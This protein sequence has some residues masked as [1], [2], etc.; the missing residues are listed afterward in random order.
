MF[1]TNLKTTPFH[2]LHVRLG[3]KMVPFA[4]YAMPVQ[5]PAGVKEE[6]LHTRAK[7]GL[8]D[9]A[10]MGQL[11]LDGEAASAAL[12]KLVVGNIQGLACKSMRYTLF[13][14]GEGGILD[15][16]IVTKW[17][18]HLHLVVNAARKD[19][20][21]QHMRDNLDCPIRTLEDRALLALQG[22]SAELALATLEPGVMELGFMK[23]DTFKIVGAE[24]QVSR[25]GYTGE[26]GFE[27]SIPTE[28]AVEIA[29]LL[30]EH[31]DV[32]PIGLGA[33]DSLRLEAGLCLYGK[34]LGA[35]T[36]PV[37]AALEWAIGKNRRE[38]GGFPGDHIILRQLAE[39]APR[40]RVG[41][42]PDG[43]A[44]ARDSTNVTNSDGNRIGEI[45]SGGFGPSID[46]PVAMGY[47]D[48]ASS[49]IGTEINAVVRGKPL[50]AK[51]AALPFV[52]ANQKRS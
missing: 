28:S 21:I 52:K 41:I 46:G 31:P 2:D 29:E 35:D 25:S 9:V 33:R 47:V 10:H 38:V 30:L 37:E 1:H 34:D 13:T 17:H 39:G 16:L 51:V 15:D 19:Q 48:A 27:I 11:L 42:R 12:E 3:A 49:V 20:D 18:D 4:G 7:A 22:P 5:Y 8:F 14:N 26:D 44:P 45:T 23:A 24:C 32:Q 6:H 43:R 36:T 40:R 50:A